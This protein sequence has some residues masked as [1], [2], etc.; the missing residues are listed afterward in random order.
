MASILRAK[1]PEGVKFSCVRCARCCKERKILLLPEDVE[2]LVHA[3]GLSVEDFA[4]PVDDLEPY[5][6]RLRKSDGACIF[7]K[8]DKCSV[9]PYRPLACRFYPFILFHIGMSYVF[10]IAGE[11]P[12]L[13]KGP[14]LERDFFEKYLSWLWAWKM[15]VSR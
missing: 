14:E 15:R 10:I 8:G 4:V 6:Y 5:K 11:C 13:G 2:R 3:T 7:L 1:I 12:G 9:Y